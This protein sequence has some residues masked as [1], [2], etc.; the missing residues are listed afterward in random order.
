MKEIEKIMKA[1][2][3]ETKSTFH[4]KVENEPYL[5]LTIEGIGRSPDGRRLV[6]V[7]H[8]QEQN[9]D[10]MRNPDVVFLV[11]EKMKGLTHGCKDGWFPVSIRNDFLGTYRESIVWDKENMSTDRREMKDIKSFS[12]VWNRNI[13]AQGFAVA[14]EKA[15]KR[16]ESLRRIAVL[17]NMSKEAREARA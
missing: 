15:A 16:E 1:T 14:A 5:P 7:C 3:N 10:L 11:D 12:N 13:K 4:I 17:G 2:G 9:G 6:S 8:Y